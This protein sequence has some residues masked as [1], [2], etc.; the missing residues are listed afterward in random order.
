MPKPVKIDP[1]NWN[2]KNIKEASRIGTARMD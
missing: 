1:K 2:I